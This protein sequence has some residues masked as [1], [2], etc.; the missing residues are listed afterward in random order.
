M[1]KNALEFVAYLRAAGMTNHTTYS[2]AFTY[3]GKWVCILLIGDGEWTM[4]DH[5]LT[6]QYD[7]FPV[8]QH[9][10]EFAWAHVHICTGGHCK[11]EPGFRKTIFGKEFDN[12]CSSEVEFINP[13]AEALKK[14]M[15]MI[16]I[17]KLSIE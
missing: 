3:N 15:Q 10:K 8:E 7:D 12:V 14:I 5:P 6:Q 9:L 1:K 2:N 11:D 13:D 4:Y 17:W 16:E